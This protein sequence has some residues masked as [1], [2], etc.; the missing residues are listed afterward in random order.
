MLLINYK[1]PI[2]DATQIEE[3]RGWELGIAFLLSHPSKQYMHS[4]L[5]NLLESITFPNFFFC[6]EELGFWYKSL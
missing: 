1:Q 6:I 4:G 5:G 2:R 3:D